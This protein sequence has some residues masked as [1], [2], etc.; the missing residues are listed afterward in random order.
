MKQILTLVAI[1]LIAL[2]FVLVAVSYGSSDIAGQ[3][4]PTAPTTTPPANEEV[5]ADVNDDGVVNAAD[6]KSIKDNIGKTDAESL[7]KYDLDN[8][9]RVS[10]YDLIIAWNA[11]YTPSSNGGSDTSETTTHGGGGSSHPLSVSVGG[12]TFGSDT[13][14]LGVI[15]LVAGIVMW[16]WSMKMR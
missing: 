4:N 8:D 12:Y 7:A 16:L 5:P 14:I 6:W 10:V 13:G 3:L 1:A 11:S 9:G 2:G 15:M